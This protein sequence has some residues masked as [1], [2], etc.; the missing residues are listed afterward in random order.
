MLAHQRR[1]LRHH[2]LNFRRHLVC[3]FPRDGPFVD[4]DDDAADY[5]DYEEDGDDCQGHWEAL[6]GGGGGDLEELGAALGALF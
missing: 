1:I 5:E 6:G 3:D 4:Y 2:F